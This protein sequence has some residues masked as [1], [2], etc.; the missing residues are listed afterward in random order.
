M[1]AKFLFFRFSQKILCDETNK[2]NKNFGLPNHSWV[3]VSRNLDRQQYCHWHTIHCQIGTIS[4]S[5]EIAKNKNFVTV[6]YGS[7]ITVSITV[8]NV[9]AICDGEGPLFL[10]VFPYFHLSSYLAHPEPCI[11]TILQHLAYPLTLKMEPAGS[12]NLWNSLPSHPVI[13]AVRASD[14]MFVVVFSKC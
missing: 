7:W 12:S 5:W 13:T 6:L 9:P 1:P 8:N 11:H 10:A 4:E 3:N 14:L 2:S